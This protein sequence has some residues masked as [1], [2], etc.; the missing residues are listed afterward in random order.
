VHQADA[1]DAGQPFGV[2]LF[3]QRSRVRVAPRRVQLDG[4][5]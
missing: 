3:Y 4:W 5:F 2:D 1:E